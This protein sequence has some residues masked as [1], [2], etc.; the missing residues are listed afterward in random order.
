SYRTLFSI[1]MFLQVIGCTLISFPNTDFLLWGLSA[2]LAGT[3]LNVT[4]IN[5][6]VTQ[7][8]HPDDKRRESAFLWNYSGMN[9]GFFL[10]FTISGYFH[11]QHAYQTLF[12]LSGI[13]NMIALALVFLNWK[14]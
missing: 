7:L 13:G 9:L 4:C 5:C 6:M 12:S 10:G 14:I 2:F 3:G 8:F 1:G 11:N